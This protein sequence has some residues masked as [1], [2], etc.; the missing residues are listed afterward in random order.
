[1]AS[2]KER[3]KNKSE[4]RAYKESLKSSDKPLESTATFRNDNLTGSAEL[5]CGMYP[6]DTTQ[7]VHTSFRV[8]AKRFV[9]RHA[10]EVGLSLIVAIII[11]LASWCIG[12]IID[13]KMSHV[14]F[15]RR[16]LVIEAEVDDLDSDSV[17]REILQ[18]QLEALR[19]E[20]RNT[21]ILQ[22]SEINNRIDL[23]ERQIELL[24]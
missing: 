14:D 18:L 3:K 6:E 2:S 21:S 1:M 11:A 23:L 24:R 16:L 4:V 17:T 19:Q 15:E 13:L 8:R 9:K 22:L 20:V 12:T 7:E 5:Q 10:F